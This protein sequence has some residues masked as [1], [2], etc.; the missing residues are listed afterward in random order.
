MFKLLSC[1]L[2]RTLLRFKPEN[3][4]YDFKKAVNYMS[5]NNRTDKDRELSE[6]FKIIEKSLDAIKYGSIT[7]II[8]D[9]KI[10]QIENNTKIRMS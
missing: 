1:R 7:L 10:I 8:Q 9:G 5:D 4:I 6:V 3:M 2:D